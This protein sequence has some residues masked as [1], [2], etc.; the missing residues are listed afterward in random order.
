MHQLSVSVRALGVEVWWSTIISDA[1]GRV[2]MPA[3]VDGRVG[4]VIATTG[5]RYRLVK[6]Q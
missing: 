6:K 5:R 1:D 3:D 2:A 4:T